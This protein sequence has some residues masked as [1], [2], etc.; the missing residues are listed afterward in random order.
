MDQDDMVKHF[1]EKGFAIIKDA[2][3]L[4]NFNAFIKSFEKTVDALIQRIINSKAIL[5][6]NLN[7]KIL[8]LSQNNDNNISMLQRLVSRSPEFYQLCAEPRL[9]LPV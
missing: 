5:E 3:S 2:I 9:A 6:N 8:F 7:D 1:N 4:S